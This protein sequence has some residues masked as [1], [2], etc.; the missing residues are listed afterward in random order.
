MYIVSRPE[1]FHS[2]MYNRG[3]TMPLLRRLKPL[4]NSHFVVHSHTTITGEY[5]HTHLIQAP[6]GANVQFKIVV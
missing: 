6:I 4:N 5:R 1:L 3:N 2:T